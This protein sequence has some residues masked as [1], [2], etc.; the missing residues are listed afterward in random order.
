LAP[1]SAKGTEDTTI[2][3]QWLKASLA[4]NT[5]IKEQAGVGGHLFFLLKSALRTDESRLLWNCDFTCHANN[6]TARFVRCF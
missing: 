2:S 3:R 4:A 1:D 6:L 5:L